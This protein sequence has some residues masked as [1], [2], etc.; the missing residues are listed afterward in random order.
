M[1]E[2]KLSLL[3]AEGIMSVR[4]Q[5]ASNATKVAPLQQ[6]S[7]LDD[8]LSVTVKKSGD[9]QKSRTKFDRF[10]VEDKQREPVSKAAGSAYLNSAKCTNTKT[11]K[12]KIM[13]SNAPEKCSVTKSAVKTGMKVG[14]T[15]SGNDLDSREPE[16][17]QEHYPGKVRDQRN[18]HGKRDE[19]VNSGYQKDKEKMMRRHSDGQYELKKINKTYDYRETLESKSSLR[20]QRKMDNEGD[21]P[22]DYVL[23]PKSA[24]PS[25]RWERRFGDEARDDDM[26]KDKLNVSRPKSSRLNS[27]IQGQVEATDTG[28]NVYP[29]VATPP[30]RPTT[31][32]GRRKSEETENSNNTSKPSHQVYSYND[33]RN[34]FKSKSAETKITKSEKSRTY[35]CSLHGYDPY[36]F[37]QEQIKV[38]KAMDLLDLNSGIDDIDLDID[39]VV[40][41]MQD[42]DMESIKKPLLSKDVINMIGN[43]NSASQHRPAIGYH[44]NNQN[45]FR[46][47]SDES[48][49]L[50]RSEQSD[51]KPTVSIASNSNQCS[52]QNGRYIQEYSDSKQ[53]SKKTPVTRT[54]SDGFANHFCPH[55]GLYNPV[56][57]TVISK[58]AKG[59]DSS[60]M[61]LR[62]QKFKPRQ[63]GGPFIRLDDEIALRKP[64]KLEPISG[65]YW[66]N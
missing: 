39:P 2:Q 9:I 16:V 34:T 22:S 25:S 41:F 63:I 15:R 24:R 37:R 1:N 10:S 54:H 28:V 3:A 31:S 6:S 26:I 17:M 12:M 53:P 35:E 64:R 32:R 19:N 21:S 11:E 57:K 48:L 47:K 50:C 60:Q 65:R 42:N 38:L 29:S 23:R 27:R 40:Y 18:R 7:R 30:P 14:Q 36:S 8:D 55:S 43:V 46:H 59:F 66:P 61:E 44:S 52:F 56:P 13:Q 20:E 58:R 51:M 49:G 62:D 4:N 45:K 33:Q 5:Y